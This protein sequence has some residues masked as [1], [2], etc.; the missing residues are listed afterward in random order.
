MNP[1]ALNSYGV[2]AARDRQ[3]V[4]DTRHIAMQTADVVT[5]RMCNSQM[6]L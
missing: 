4:G 3:Q 2:I 1:V 6:K 5:L